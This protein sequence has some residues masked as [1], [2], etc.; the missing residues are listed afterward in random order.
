MKFSIRTKQFIENISLAVDVSSRSVLKTASGVHDSAYKLMIKVQKDSINIVAFSGRMAIQTAISSLSAQ[1]VDYKVQGTGT[2][3]VNSSDIMS[4]LASFDAQQMIVIQKSESAS[5]GVQLKISRKADSD[6]FQTI[7]CFPEQIVIPDMNF[8]PQK[9]LKIDREYFLQGSQK[10][11]F[12]LGFEQQKPQ[13]L[14]WIFRVSN[15]NKVRF[16]AGDNRRFIVYDIQGQNIVQSNPATTNLLFSK[17][18]TPSIIKALI[19][20]SDSHFTIKQSTSKSKSMNMILTVG[21]H[22]ILMAHMDPNIQW[23]NQNTLLKAQFDNSVVVRLTQWDT[24]S[25]AIVAAYSDSARN[26]LRPQVVDVV[27]DFKAKQINVSVDDIAK[28]NRKVSILTTNSQL[29]D[30]VKSR[31]SSIYLTELSSKGD[32]AGGMQIDFNDPIVESD[33]SLRLKPFVFKFY[34]DGTLNSNSIVKVN[35]STKVSYSL[36]FIIIPS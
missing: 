12:A 27:F 20:C 26:S 7:P 21:Q 8:I 16:A 35:P 28:M 32:K 10:V 31:F 17:Q 9:T 24:V 2:I 36:S 29:K 22:K 4:R 14:Y 18:H 25:K 3:T 33:G 19:K 13:Y 11:S 5:G 6:Q 23:P 15:S 34:S 1:K 30:A